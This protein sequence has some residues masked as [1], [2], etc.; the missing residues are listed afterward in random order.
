LRLRTTDFRRFI[1]G[2][3]VS[4]YN[5]VMMKLKQ[6]IFSAIFIISCISIGF[7]QTDRDKGIELFNK[8]DFQGAVDVLSQVVKSNENDIIALYNLGL[9]YEK[10]NQPKDAMKSFGKAIDIGASIIRKSVQAAY[11]GKISPENQMVF[12]NLVEKYDKDFESGYLSAGRFVSLNPKEAK[13]SNWIEKIEIIEAYAPNSEI[14]QSVYSDKD[15]TTKPKITS[16]P[17]ASGGFANGTVKVRVLLIGNGK[18]GAVIPISQ[19]G[20]VGELLPNAIKATK[21][22]KFQPATKDGKPV[23]NWKIIE[24]RSSI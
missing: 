2:K 21:Q 1:A 5:D 11:G 15:L 17:R 12:K 23:S 10:L 8:G 14:A 18:I 13:S 20:D 6:L 9:A 16:T 3:S 4:D 19:I 24:Y 22:I 7:A